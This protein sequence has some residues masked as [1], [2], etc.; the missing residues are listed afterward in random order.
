MLSLSEELDGSEFGGAQGSFSFPCD[1][2][3]RTLAIQ[4]PLLETGVIWSEIVYAER[5]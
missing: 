3:D 2:V 4:V 1:R 5:S